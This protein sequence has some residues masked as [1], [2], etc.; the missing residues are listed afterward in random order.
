MKKQE[1]LLQPYT[2]TINKKDL[3]DLIE[4]DG[5]ENIV[6]N[7]LNEISVAIRM[8][9][10]VSEAFG[11][12]SC[13]GYCDDTRPVHGDHKDHEVCMVAF[14]CRKCWIKWSLPVHDKCHK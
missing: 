1:T 3:S 2:F 10:S 5:L 14:L 13:G 6:K 7:I 12:L 9:S 11:C 4:R 8:N